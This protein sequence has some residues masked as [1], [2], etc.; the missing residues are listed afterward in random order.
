MMI[1][2]RKLRFSY[3]R[4]MPA[5]VWL[6]AA[7][8]MLLLSG[9]LTLQSPG[10]AYRKVVDGQQSFDA[11]IV[12]GVP[13]DGNDWSNTMHCRVLWSYL[14]Y[15]NG[16]VKNIIYSGGAV[17]SPYYE[18]KIMGLYAQQLG[19][20]AAHIFYDTL[21]EHS[22]ENVYYSYELARQL[23]FKTI[24]LATEYDQ[25]ILLKKFVRK[26]F[27]TSIAILPIVEQMVDGYVHPKLVID[28]APARKENF[29]SILQRESLGQRL[30]GTAGSKVPV[31]ET[32]PRK[33]SK[34]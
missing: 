19:V 6:V 14:L 8:F 21:A 28:P 15:K 12:P 5:G 4:L 1:L 30:G 20:P 33:F 7:V 11:V 23:G 17:Y 31:P 9:C 10:R 29:T 2:F 13:F 24:A 16:Y 32:K 3:L 18:A 27:Q 34:L 22:T 25:A 26:R